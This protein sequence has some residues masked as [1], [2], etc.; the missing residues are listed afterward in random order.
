MTGIPVV[1]TFA[2]NLS[3]EICATELGLNPDRKTILIMSGGDGLN[4]IYSL[5]E[6]LLTVKEN[7]QLIVLA[8]KNRRLLKRL[9]KL[10]K[11]N[12]SRLHTFG[13][14]KS[15]EKIMTAADIIITKPGG[16]TIAECLACG[17]PIILANPQGGLEDQ[18]ASLLLEQNAAKL[19]IGTKNIVRQIK[20]LLSNNSQL[21]NLANAS[22]QIGNPNAAY[23]VL[24]IV[25]KI[26]QK[27]PE[28]IY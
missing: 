24:K 18:N 26:H 20:Q 22:R 21:S 25:L 7:F 2:D 19:A 10:R 17:L 23:D 8:G 27:L 9:K 12:S 14:I 11:Q 4:W 16:S 3:K 1:P 28:N 5:T 6:Q 13:F 15:V